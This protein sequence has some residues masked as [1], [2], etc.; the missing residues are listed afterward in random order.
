M[1]PLSRYL[2]LRETTE[3]EAV[4]SQIVI[5]GRRLLSPSWCCGRNINRVRGAQTNEANAAELLPCRLSFLIAIIEAVD[6]ME[7][8]R[9]AASGTDR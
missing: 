2:R 3:R 4:V 5:R 9:T 1:L 8:A 6:Q 7:I